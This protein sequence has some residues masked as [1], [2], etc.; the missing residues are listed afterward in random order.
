M[1]NYISSNN[2]FLKNEFEDSNSSMEHSLNISDEENNLIYQSDSPSYIVLS[3]SK[4]LS[5]IIKRSRPNTP[6]EYSNSKVDSTRLFDEFKVTSSCGKD[7]GDQKLLLKDQS[8]LH[9]SQSLL[10]YNQSRSLLY[11]DQN[12]PFEIF[13]LLPD[14]PI[15]MSTNYKTCLANNS[16]IERCLSNST[17]DETYS[18]NK[19]KLPTNSKP[20]FHRNPSTPTVV[21]KNYNNSFI[22]SLSVATLKL[23]SLKILPL[24][25]LEIKPS[26]PTTPFF[27]VDVGDVTGIWTE[28]LTNIEFV[29]LGPNFA[30]LPSAVDT[31]GHITGI[32]G[33]SYQTPNALL[34][35]A[36]NTIFRPI[37]DLH[38]LA[39]TTNKIENTTKQNSPDSEVKKDVENKTNSPT[40][41][42]KVPDSKSFYMPTSDS[43]DDN[44][45]NQSQ[46][47]NWSQDEGS[48][49]I[50]T[51]DC[52]SP[53]LLEN[54]CEI[55]KSWA[56]GQ[57]LYSECVSKK[58]LPEIHSTTQI[59]PKE[60]MFD[61][62][63]ALDN[64]RE[65]HS[66][67]NAVVF[68]NS[69]LGFVSS[70]ISRA[71]DAPACFT[72]KEIMKN[73][74]PQNNKDKILI[75][76]PDFKCDDNKPLY[77]GDKAHSLQLTD[78]D[79]IESNKT[80]VQETSSLS[81]IDSSSVWHGTCPNMMKYLFH[82]YCR[83]EVTN[84]TESPHPFLIVKSKE[85]KL[86]LDSIKCLNKEREITMVHEALK[87]LNYN[88]CT[89]ERDLGTSNNGENNIYMPSIPLMTY[90]NKEDSNIS[91]DVHDSVGIVL[92]NSE[93]IAKTSTVSC[94]I[95]ER[96]ISTKVSQLLVSDSNSSKSELSLESSEIM[97]EC[98]GKSPT[99]V[100]EPGFSEDTMNFILGE[101]STKAPYRYD[102]SPLLFSSDEE[103]DLDNDQ[104][105]KE[106]Q[107]EPQELLQE[108][109][110]Q[111]YEQSRLNRLQELLQGVP[112]P[113]SYTIPQLNVVEMLKQLKDNHELM[114]SY[115]SL[116][117]KRKNTGKP[118]EH[119]KYLPQSATFEEAITASW[120]ESKQ[121]F[122]H[123]ISYNTSVASEQFELLC[124]KLAERFVGNEMA[125]SCNVVQSSFQAGTGANHRKRRSTGQSPGRRLSHLARR[126]QIFS[127]ANLMNRSAGKL[128]LSNLSHSCGE[129]RLI[130]VESKKKENKKNKTGRVSHTKHMLENDSHSLP[131]KVAATKRALFKSPPLDGRM[132]PPSSGSLCNTNSDRKRIQYFEEFTSSNTSNVKNHVSES[133]NNSMALYNNSFSVNNNLRLLK[134]CQNK[135]S[136]NLKCHVNEN[137]KRT[138]A[139]LQ[140]LVRRGKCPRKLFQSP[141]KECKTSNQNILSKNVDTLRTEN[142]K[143]I[144]QIIGKDSTLIETANIKQGGHLATNSTSG[145]LSGAHKK[146]LLW[147]VAEA[148]RGVGIG[149]LNPLF[150]PC[151]S[152]LARVCRSLLPD[153]MTPCNNQHN[154]STSERMLKLAQEHVQTVVKNREHTSS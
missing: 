92:N 141:D 101:I 6:H 24:V 32:W 55:V 86:A 68:S 31:S 123:G 8:L 97:D 54:S 22:S 23:Q 73:T 104:E 5:L 131:R 118:I 25:S 127:S 91:G 4:P 9:D 15:E 80:N 107:L 142:L 103:N 150:R 84:I 59:T 99:K 137:G 33:Y 48:V 152:S 60:P 79:E 34:N 65:S 72:V 143:S 153:L 113:P 2:N 42:I 12:E 66:N 76:Y 130:M 93:S 37:S 70:N 27:G 114:V 30:L 16:L 94:K 36:L 140:P 145:D 47:H 125:S 1:N 98:C 63:K 146:K 77:M 11:D 138:I 95:P 21:I 49:I 139:E 57:L 109:K 78:C 105:G 115:S 13:K 14:T 124:Q 144:E 28:S 83:N 100:S 147:A 149:L 129:K 17:N 45:I 134:H 135:S 148:L 117:I 108:A 112:P 110:I 50:S 74:S 128:P 41:Q 111:S 106:I 151:A 102:H 61:F 29:Y 58:A 56:E 53:L 64:T 132:V 87:E 20:T 10:S 121:C 18:D 116:G 81:D 26:V 19:L 7:K 120:P 44:N 82:D 3:G 154:G 39:C 122:Y 90:T 40:Y 75:E 51:N 88:L 67:D 85:P 35:H 126:R 96:T 43:C 69:K 89:T 133:K 136:S 119:S 38:D 52:P 62:K 71:K 46:Y